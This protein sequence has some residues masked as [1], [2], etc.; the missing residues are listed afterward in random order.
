MTY[1]LATMAA[2][3]IL[4]YPEGSRDREARAAGLA[5]HQAMLLTQELP[6][7]R[8]TI[9]FILTTRSNKPTAR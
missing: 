8:V 6:R 7:G 9:D 2:L 3:I 4:Q 5:A 1:S